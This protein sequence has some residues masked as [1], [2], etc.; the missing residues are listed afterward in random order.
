MDSRGFRHFRSFHGKS[1]V[2]DS[3]ERGGFNQEV[4]VVMVTHTLK[5]LP[6]AS[7]R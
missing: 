3:S 6:F 7:K 4:R 5:G 1:K 2:S